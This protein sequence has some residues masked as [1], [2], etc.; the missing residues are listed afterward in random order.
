MESHDASIV[1]TD[2][3]I[4][5]QNLKSMIYQWQQS[6]LK[7][8][9]AF[10]RSLEANFRSF[11]FAFHSEDEPI[12]HKIFLLCRFLVMIQKAEQTNMSASF[13][14]SSQVLL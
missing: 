11:I 5:A 1:G 9:L 14:I 8:N 7:T 10:P 3:S 13:A 12:M 4:L 6:R 2:I